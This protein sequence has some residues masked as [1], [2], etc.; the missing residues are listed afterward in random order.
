MTCLL[1]FYQL[2]HHLIIKR[3]LIYFTYLLEKL[4]GGVGAGGGGARGW[5]GG[6]GR[7]QQQ[8]KQNEFEN[9][10]LHEHINTVCITR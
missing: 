5:G 2:G 3:L 6:G 8:L 10:C 9:A 4:E 7:T 1:S